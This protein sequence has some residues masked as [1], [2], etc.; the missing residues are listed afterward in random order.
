MGICCAPKDAVLGFEHVRIG[1]RNAVTVT[2]RGG[3]EKEVRFA[4]CA[5]VLPW[6]VASVC[7]F[8]P[9]SLRSEVA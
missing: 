9:R 2:R 7:V 4:F 8:P 1:C 6:E 5:V 3:K